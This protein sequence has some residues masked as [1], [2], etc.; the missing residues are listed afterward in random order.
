V[1]D[2]EVTV[3]VGED[4]FPIGGGAGVEGGG[5]GVA[6]QAGD[7]GDVGVVEGQF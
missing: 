1:L 5:G 7:A 6:D 4:L 2:E 3:A